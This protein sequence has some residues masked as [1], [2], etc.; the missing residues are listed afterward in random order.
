MEGVFYAVFDRSVHAVA[1]RGGSAV[2]K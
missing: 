1:L 2:R